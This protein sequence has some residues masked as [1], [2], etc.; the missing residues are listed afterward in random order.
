[1]F[2]YN[3]RA[4]FYETDAMGII[5]HGNYILYLEEARVHW[6]RQLPFYTDGNMLSDINFPVLHCEVQFKNPLYFDDDVSIEVQASA[7][8]VRLTF[9]YVL[10]TKRFDKPVAFGKTVHAVMDMK[11]RK[12]IRLP[13]EIL[14]GIAQEARRG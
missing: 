6:L 9:E 5:H 11:T 10:K 4:Q 13:Q 8:K 14:D 2:V 3:R 1:M 7:E 12:P